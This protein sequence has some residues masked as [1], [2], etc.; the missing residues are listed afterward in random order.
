MKMFG[1]PRKQP[2]LDR[3]LL[4]CIRACLYGILYVLSSIGHKKNTEW[5]T[6][7]QKKNDRHKFSYNIK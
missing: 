4:L 5:W 6:S 7:S 1:A 2:V 3:L